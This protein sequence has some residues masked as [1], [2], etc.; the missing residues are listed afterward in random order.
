MTGDWTTKRRTSKWC[1]FAAR[2][3]HRTETPLQMRSNGSGTDRSRSETD[4]GVRFSRPEAH[5]HSAS[6]NSLLSAARCSFK[7][8]WQSAYSHCRGWL[9]R[10]CTRHTESERLYHSQN[11]HCRRSA[12]SARSGAAQSEPAS[13]A[14]TQRE[15]YIKRSRFILFRSLTFW[16]SFTLESPQS[17]AY[18]A[19]HF[20]LLSIED[21]PGS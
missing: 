18:L 2:F 11:A 6:S 17:A 19:V 12:A 10:Q 14:S 15:A 8:C 9:E 5:T 4:R 13:A 3:C 16:R 1:P 20:A 7:W 21:G